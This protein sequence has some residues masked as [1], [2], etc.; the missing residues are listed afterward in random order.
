M[1]VKNSHDEIKVPAD[2]EARLEALIDRL[3]EAEKQSRKRTVAY[4]WTGCAAACVTVLIFAGLLLTPKKKS[5]DTG[6]SETVS[7]IEDSLTPNNVNVG[8]DGFSGGIRQI[9]D[10][11]TAYR[12][13]K[14]A[15]ELMSDNFNRGI[16]EIEKSSE[17]ISKTFKY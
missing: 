16:D 1:K 12:E 11:E 13:V 10:P 2:L 9:D 6:V 17:I 14:K 8:G 15:L 5:F 4:L 3:A 7:H